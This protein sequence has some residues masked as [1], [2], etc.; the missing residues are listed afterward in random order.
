MIL[1]VTLALLLSFLITTYTEGLNLCLHSPPFQ[2]TCTLT[3]T[4]IKHTHTQTDI[5]HTHTCSK[6][7]CPFAGS[8]T[9]GRPVCKNCS[10]STGASAMQAFLDLA[11]VLLYLGPLECV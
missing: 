7:F 9:H 1:H 2:H 3:H 11:N 5:K 8:A 10:Q 4:D 6:V